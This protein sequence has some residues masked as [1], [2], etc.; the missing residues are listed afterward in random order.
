[1]PDNSAPIRTVGLNVELELTPLGER[2][3]AEGKV[4]VP[5]KVTPEIIELRKQAVDAARKKSRELKA[6]RRKQIEKDL[7]SGKRR[8]LP[9]MTKREK[10]RTDEQARRAKAWEKADKERAAAAKKT[11]KG[12]EKA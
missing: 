8:P 6:K 12:D 4:A 5:R 2:L 7:E 3:A 1:M 11:G 9:P 10:M